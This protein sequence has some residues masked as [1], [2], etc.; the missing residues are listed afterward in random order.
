MK[1]IKDLFGKGT[2][3]S[4]SLCFNFVKNSRVYSP[5]CRDITLL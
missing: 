5:N 2:N 4:N 3:T 1:F